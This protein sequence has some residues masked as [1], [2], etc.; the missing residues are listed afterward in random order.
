MA[1]PLPKPT[2]EDVSMDLV[3]SLIDRL[4]AD[5]QK[6]VRNKLNAKAWAEKWD[7]LT[8]E[9]REQNKSLPPLT[10]E[11]IFAEWK[12]IKSELRAERA[13]SNH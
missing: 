7:A 9:I 2:P 1:T 12:A 6:Q 13:Q 11:E 10:E 5:E 3:I 8:N 4:P